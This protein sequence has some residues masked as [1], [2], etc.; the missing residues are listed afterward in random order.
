MSDFFGGDAEMFG[1]SAR[2]CWMPLRCQ[3]CSS[4]RY[5]ASVYSFPPCPCALIPSSENVSVLLGTHD[6]FV[7]ALV[8][9]TALNDNV[10][11]QLR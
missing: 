10:L 3:L 2:S 5:D 11:I 8:P 9:V 4:L 7:A 6:Y 1:L